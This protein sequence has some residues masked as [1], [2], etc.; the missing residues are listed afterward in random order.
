LIVRT[1]AYA[2]GDKARTATILGMSRWR[3]CWSRRITRPASD[4]ATC[5][6]AWNPTSC[7]KRMVAPT[8]AVIEI[9]AMAYRENGNPYMSL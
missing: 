7:T 1:L 2:G 8:A 4:T 3:G 5:T 6:T 9:A